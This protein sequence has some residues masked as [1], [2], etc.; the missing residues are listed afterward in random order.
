MCLFGR[1]YWYRSSKYSKCNT[2]CDILLQTCY[3]SQIRLPESAD[4][5]R[6]RKS[7]LL[8]KQALLTATS[9]ELSNV[10]SADIDSRLETLKRNKEELMRLVQNAVDKLLHME[11]ECFTKINLTACGEIKNGHT[12][13]HSILEEITEHFE[14]AEYLESVLNGRENTLPVLRSKLNTISNELKNLDS[15]ISIAEKREVAEEIEV[16]TSSDF[17]SASCPALGQIKFT[18]DSEAC[19]QVI[20]CPSNE[21]FDSR[22]PVNATTT[23][24]WNVQSCA[25]DNELKALN[26][27]DSFTEVMNSAAVKFTASL[28][29]VKIKRSWM[30][31]DMLEQTDHYTMVRVFHN[32]YVYK[33]I[34]KMVTYSFSCNYSTIVSKLVDYMFR[35]LC[36][37][38]S[39]RLLCSI[40]REH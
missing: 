16:S 39:A 12:A 23:L 25:V 38:S 17:E 35:F 3:I 27:F 37:P 26:Q 11:V 19:C 8:T 6:Y 5:L 4:E 2:N 32:I 34:S 29:K 9:A 21:C 24:M 36:K 30:D 40:D 31:V 10:T 15:K 33:N 1:I 22:V 13:F 20:D 14:Q 18:F 28:Q 7:Q